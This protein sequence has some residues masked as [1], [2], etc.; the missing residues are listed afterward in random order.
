MM[1]PAMSGLRKDHKV[2]EK[3]QESTGL[4][5]RPV[6]HASTA[7]NNILSSILSAIIKAVAEEAENRATASSEEMVAT[8]KR[9]NE[10]AA[11][12]GR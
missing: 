11:T 6:C 3:G 4:P 12:R 9:E 1:P 7:H 2:V 10:N 5:L 8:L